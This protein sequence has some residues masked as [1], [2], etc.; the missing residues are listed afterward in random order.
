MILGQTLLSQACGTGGDPQDPQGMGNGSVGI[1]WLQ[2]KSHFNCFFEVIGFGNT[3]QGFK[4][5][6]KAKLGAPT[7]LC[8][9]K[10]QCFLV[11]SPRILGISCSCF[12]LA[13]FSPELLQF[14]LPDSSPVWAAHPSPAHP[15]A[16][17]VTQLLFP[18][19]FGEFFSK[20]KKKPLQGDPAELAPCQPSPA[21]AATRLSSLIPLSGIILTGF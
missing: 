2:Q 6:W 3:I 10:T 19:G 9:L 1:C 12:L 20:K 8:S 18:A 11:D 14:T 13:A 15:S 21:S 16:A 4:R 7:G 5:W 17:V